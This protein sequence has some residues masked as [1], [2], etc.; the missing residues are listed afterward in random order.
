MYGKITVILTVFVVCAFAGEQDV[1]D[2]TDNDFSTRVAETETTLVMF[3]APW[4]VKHFFFKFSI[5]IY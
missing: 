1:L 2:L 3:Y 4:Y 5:N